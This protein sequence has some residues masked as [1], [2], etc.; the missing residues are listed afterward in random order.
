M[1]VLL[2]TLVAFS[3]FAS[4][5][6][7]SNTGSNVHYLSSY[8]K[9][10][11]NWYITTSTDK[12]SS[13]FVFKAKYQIHTSKGWNTIVTALITFNFSKINN[14]TTKMTE[15]TYT[16]GK[17]VS[18][19]S[20]TSKTKLTPFNYAKAFESHEINYFKTTM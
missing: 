13:T 2:V 12:K 8:E 4:A 16:N 11:N 6:T 7:V 3:G 15:K 10:I 1:G 14:T 20:S 18:N 9:S 19:K 17:L 5:A